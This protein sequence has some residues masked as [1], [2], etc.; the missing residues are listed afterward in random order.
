MN[1][2]VYVKDPTG[3]RDGTIHRKV[4]AESEFAK[5]ISAKAAIILKKVYILYKLTLQTPV[6][7]TQM[8]DENISTS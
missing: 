8:V 6:E 3:T 4:L 5:D 7:P 1:L 2:T